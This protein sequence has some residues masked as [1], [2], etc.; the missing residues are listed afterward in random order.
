MLKGHRLRKSIQFIKFQNGI[1]WRI[2][3]AFRARRRATTEKKVLRTCCGTTS[4]FHQLEDEFGRDTVSGVQAIAERGSSAGRILLPPPARKYFS[5]LRDS[6]HPET[7]VAART[8]P[9]VRTGRPRSRR[10]LSFPLMAPARSKPL[11]PQL[12]RS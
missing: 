5:N 1:N 12:I 6:L 8:R 10:I 7:V 11:D 2:Q 3:G 4:S 9:P